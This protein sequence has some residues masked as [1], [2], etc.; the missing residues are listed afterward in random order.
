MRAIRNTP[1]TTMVA[2]WMRADT[3]VGPAM[4]SGSQ[5]CSGNWPDFEL[6]AAMRHRAAASMTPWLSVPSRAARLVS[7]MPKLPTPKNKMMT[8]MIMPMSPTRLVRKALR[9]ALLLACSSHQWPM[10]TNELTPTSSQLS[11]SCSV[12]W[13]MTS[14][15]IEKLKKERKA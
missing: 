8:P 6:T 10:S 11:S 13:L 1:A 14:I 2:A 7:T 4:A 5:V 9:A 3:G 15:S 12:L